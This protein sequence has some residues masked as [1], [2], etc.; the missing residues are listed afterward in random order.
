[1][2]AVKDGL[3]TSQGDK[4]ELFSLIAPLRC[5]KPAIEC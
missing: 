2:G 5:V 4:D 1:M 3:C